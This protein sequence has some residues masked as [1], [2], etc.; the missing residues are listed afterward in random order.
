[1]KGEQDT[2]HLVKEIYVYSDGSERVVEIK[3]NPNAEEIV[4]AVEE[5]REEIAEVVEVSASANI[6]EVNNDENVGVE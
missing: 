2:K 1:M 4:K 5:A 6:A 3:P